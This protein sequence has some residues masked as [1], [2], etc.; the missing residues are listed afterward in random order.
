MRPSSLALLVAWLHLGVWAAEGYAN[1]TE[2]DTDTTNSI[3]PPEVGS[4]E[5]WSQFIQGK[6]NVI[7]ISKLPVGRGIKW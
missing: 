3:T 2:T 1:D 6:Y 5:Q 4:V 7:Q